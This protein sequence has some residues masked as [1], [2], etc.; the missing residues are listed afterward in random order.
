MGIMD[1]DKVD[2]YLNW[3]NNECPVEGEWVFEKPVFKLTVDRKY[4]PK[5]TRWV[6]KI[7]GCSHFYECKGVGLTVLFTY[8]TF[9]ENILV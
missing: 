6:E 1:Y 4:Q 5:L 2:E 8:S 3:L 7:V 9:E